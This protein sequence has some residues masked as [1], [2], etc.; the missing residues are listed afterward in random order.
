MGET[1]R[2]GRPRYPSLLTLKSLILV[3]NKY[4]L[5]D[6]ADS[7]AL[8]ICLAATDVASARQIVDPLVKKL[9]GIYRHPYLSEYAKQ[10]TLILSSSIIKKVGSI[11]SK[12]KIHGLVPDLDAAMDE[13]FSLAET[14]I[15]S[16]DESDILFEPL[17]PLLELLCAGFEVKPSQ[18]ELID[19]FER[20]SHVI[21]ITPYFLDIVPAFRILDM[22]DSWRTRCLAESGTIFKEGE[23]IYYIDPSESCLSLL[24]LSLKAD[25]AFNQVGGSCPVDAD[26]FIDAL[27][28]IVSSKSSSLVSSTLS[29]FLAS[30]IRFSNH[31]QLDIS[32][33]EDQVL[34]VVLE[35]LKSPARDSAIHVYKLFERVLE[36]GISSVGAKD[37]V[38]YEID[39]Y[40]HV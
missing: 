29:N 3:A 20:Q 19:D 15:S 37:L 4:D 7:L 11:P 35:S 9:A 14:F 2:R 39:F 25:L 5:Q 12:I 17:L 23:K 10:R 32:Q 27:Q 21:K 30:S 34:S 36:A 16:S 1:F 26:L 18:R 33:I 28:R 38:C 31:Y 13:L 8:F 6:E 24:S 40:F 22:M